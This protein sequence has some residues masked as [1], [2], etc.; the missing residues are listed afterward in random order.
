M[1]FLQT[2]TGFYMGGVVTIPPSLMV[3]VSE[4]TGN[5]VSVPS[6]ATPGSVITSISAPAQAI[7]PATQSGITVDN[8]GQYSAMTPVPT[9]LTFVPGS[10]SVEGGDSNVSGKYTVSYCTAAMGFIPGECTAQMTG[11]YKTTYPYIET[12]LNPSVNIAGGNTLTLPTITASYTVNAADT[13]GSTI[14]SYETEFVASTTVGNTMP[15]TTTVLDA[16]PSINSC[17]GTGIGCTPPY[18]APSPRWTLTVVAAPTVTAVSPNTGPTAGGTGVTITGTGFTGA[19]AVD[20]GANA[21]TGV[22]VNSDTSITATSPAGQRHGRRDR[23]RAGR[24][25]CRQPAG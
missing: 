25:L 10:L 5:G 12:F 14:S 21:A 8:V 2:E 18:Q 19:T 3:G 22:T 6:T 13:I 20:F 1:T 9:G 15:F 17:S 24:H 11:N 4:D 16:Y 23:D 7:I